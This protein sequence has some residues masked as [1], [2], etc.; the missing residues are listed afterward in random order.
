MSKTLHLGIGHYGIGSKDGVNTVISR[1]VK[2]LQAIDPSLRITLFGKLSP[3]YRDFIKP[4][5]GSLDY[6]N[7]D[8]FDSASEVRKLPGESIGDQQVHDYIWQGTN[9]AENL[10]ERLA[11]MDVIMVENLGI[12]MDPVVT[13]AFYLYS[14]YCYTHREPKRFIF[15]FHDFV[16]QRPANFANIKKFQHPRLGIVPHWHSVLFPAYPNI[17]YISI[18]RYDRLRLIEHGIEEENIYYVPNSID[19]SIVPPDDRGLELRD[20][21]IRKEN[22]D[23][24]VRFVLYPVRCVRRKNV[25]EAMFLIYL[26]NLLA[27]GVSSRSEYKSGD[28]YHLLVSIRPT[29][30]DDAQY[31]EQL[32][33]FAK[34]NRLPVSIGLDGL[35]SLQREFDP[36]DP[37]KLRRYSIGDLYRIA[38]LVITTS[39]LEGFGFTYLEPWLLDRAVIGR[40]IPFIT[41]DFQATG[42]KLGHL[43]TA[44][45]VDRQD[46]K[47][48]GQKLTTPDKSLQARLKKILRLEQKG[49]VDRIMDSNETVMTA[50][51]KLLEPGKRKR[52]IERNRKV[53]EEVYS[54]EN[55]GS[56]LY[57]A[58]TAT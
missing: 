47:D 24:N 7:I 26:F 31:T 46:F 52:L 6:L 5:P 43:Y 21:I 41:L 19:P 20:K 51:L 35:V 39:I 36:K 55:I 58:L 17:R 54:L 9:L 4:V 48:I 32:I 3:D 37:T 30:G 56:Q 40:S 49:Y 33:D 18:N 22:L 8:E 27:G 16:Q 34:E 50:T 28:H 11:D 25:E 57:R 38:D 2:A 13:Y 10:V 1:N 15:R 14:Q 42:M 29:S 12:G 44:L 53:V 23:P 45:V